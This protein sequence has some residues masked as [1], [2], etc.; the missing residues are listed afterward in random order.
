MAKKTLT[1]ASLMKEIDLKLQEL[2]LL[3]S[4]LQANAHPKKEELEDY[5][6]RF[7]EIIS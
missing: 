6:K 1:K 2:N 4:V 3:K 5:Q 7:K